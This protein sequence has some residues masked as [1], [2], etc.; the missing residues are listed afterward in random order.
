MELIQGDPDEMQDESP[1]KVVK[2]E[3][4]ETAKPAKP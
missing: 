4:K 2:P 1:V 3:T